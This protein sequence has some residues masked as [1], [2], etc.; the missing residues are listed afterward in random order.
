MPQLE[1]PDELADL[2]ANWLHCYGSHSD[3]GECAKDCRL[4]FTVAVT[5]RIRESV[6]NEKLLQN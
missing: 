4:C 3:D 5:E 1:T 6:K 2:I